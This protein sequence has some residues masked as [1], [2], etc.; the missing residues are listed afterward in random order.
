[1][2]EIKEAIPE[3]TELCPYCDT[4]VEIPRINEGE[5]YRC[6]CC[7]NIIISLYKNPILKPFLYAIIALFLFVSTELIPFIKIDCAGTSLS[8]NLR[9]T[10]TTLYDS[11]FK[12]ISI[13]VYVFMQL[14][15]LLCILSIIFINGVFLLKKRNN[16]QKFL[17]RHLFL[18]REWSMVDVFLI[19]ILVSLIKLYSMVDVEILGGFWC[20][21]LFCFFYKSSLSSMQKY[22]IWSKLLKRKKFYN[23]LNIVHQTGK[24]NNL[25]LCENCLSINDISN[26]RCTCCNYKIRQRKNHSVQKSLAFL[27]AAIIFYIPSNIFPMMITLYMGKYSY[28]T[29]L[30]GVEF[31][32]NTESYFVAIVI[33]I[34]SIMIP[35]IKI[36][37]LIF[38]I[39]SIQFCKTKS[40]IGKT[41]LYRLTEFIGKWSMVDVFVVT[42]MSTLI[43][44]GSILSIYPGVGA[45]SFCGVVLLTML[46][47]NSLDIR[48]LWIESN[49]SKEKALQKN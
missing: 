26:K 9:E 1:M 31:M 36:A 44:M 25:A 15:P 4:I 38:I 20:F 16:F 33:F 28:S 3:H 2:A 14:I 32:W 40:L 30:E 8:M 12:I 29:I 39:Y 24:N 10:I 42:I 19:G 22:H 46:S 13:F 6:P 17:A 35:I 7:N 48:E 5:R 37:I 34:A 49:N 21:F 45:I 23:R 18:I 43:Q 47:A 11:D 27:I 41:K